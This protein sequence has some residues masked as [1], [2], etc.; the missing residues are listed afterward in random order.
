MP[1]RD[2]A[3]ARSAFD[4]DEFL[5]AV[6]RYRSATRQLEVIG[7]S[8]ETGSVGKIRVF[9][10]VRFGAH[11]SMVHPLAIFFRLGLFV[12]LM[13]S[14][15][16]VHLR[17]RARFG[18]MKALTDYTVLLAPYNMLMVLFSRV[19]ARPYAPVSA[20]PDLA[21]LQAHW[22]EIR[23]EAL[24]LNE[25][26]RI[27]VATG[28]NDL[29]FNSFFR[30]GWKRFY[31]KWYGEE[32]ASARAACPRTVELLSTIP[33]IK[34]AM[35][36]SLPPAGKLVRHRDPYAGSLRYHLGLA[37]P[38]SPACYI[39]VDGQRY[40]WRDGEAV[41]FD[42]TF[43]HHAENQ[44]D[45]QRV[46][47]FCDVERPIRSRVLAAINR[48]FADH[49]MAASAAPNEAGER[50]GGINRFFQV[51]YKVRLQ[52]KKLKAANRSLY[53]LSKWVAILGGLYLIFFSWI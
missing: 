19:N 26:G 23:A 38:N 9:H 41:V 51:A 24:R 47:L 10:M 52:T 39:E 43:I 37:T 25:A 45:E 50:V 3:R 46:I 30:S 22:Q 2:A 21:P 49:I 36:A 5:A 15:L 7:A 27:G 6:A 1:Q 34:G 40:F 13:G 11:P 32:L 20:F 53:Y 44:T 31:L 12:L 42:E 4:T 48:W 18:L 29:G 14:A 16:F 35:F 17:G 33:S 28:Y 8:R